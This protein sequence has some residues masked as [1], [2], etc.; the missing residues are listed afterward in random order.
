VQR[1]ITAGIRG[2]RMM[3]KT[4]I[5]NNRISGAHRRDLLGGGRLLRVSLVG[6][7]LAGASAPAQANS[8]DLTFRYTV[9]QGTCDVLVDGAASKTLTLSNLT[10]PANL[11]GKAWSIIQDGT[12]KSFTLTLANCSGA[13]NPA[14]RPGIQITSSAYATTGSAERQQKILTGTTND[15]GVGVVL[16]LTNPPAQG[17]LL[18]NDDWIDL[19]A[20]NTAASNGMAKTLYIGLACGDAT[21]CAMGKVKPGKVTSGVTATFTF[22]YH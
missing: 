9:V 17:G 19:G 12:T 15:T 6:V 3:R 14:T 4:M 1:V 2:R 22:A 13:A 5:K 7:C 16:S 20:N 11:I 10:N 18:K 8:I 21:D